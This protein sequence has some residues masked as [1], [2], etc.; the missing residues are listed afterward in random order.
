[1]IGIL[2]EI[3]VVRVQ[4]FIVFQI[5]K[6]ELI[7]VKVAL[8]LDLGLIDLVDLSLLIGVLEELLQQVIGKVPLPSKGDFL[9]L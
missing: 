3:F 6:K 1:M 9:L 7:Q 4:V 8:V 5:V 2:D